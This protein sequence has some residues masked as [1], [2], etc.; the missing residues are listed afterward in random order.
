LKA[1]KDL[2][3]TRDELNQQISVFARDA[4][5]ARQRG[6]L[7][8]AHEL[9]EKAYSL[10]IEMMEAFPAEVTSSDYQ[11]AAFLA[12]NAELYAIA[13]ELALKGLSGV[14][15]EYIRY[16][17]YQLLEKIAIKTD[18]TLGKLPRHDVGMPT[19]NPE[20][21]HTALNYIFERLTK[22]IAT[23]GT[24]GFDFILKSQHYTPIQF[25]ILNESY[26]GQIMVWDNSR[27][28]DIWLW[29]IDSEDLVQE[30]KA[31]DDI[32]DLLIVMGRVFEAF[33]EQR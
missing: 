24:Q 13:K 30:N 23:Q 21:R 26:M 8:I 18:D 32:A 29:K 33:E 3:P 22:M 1:G 5:A 19:V 4:H 12:Y 31:Y 2:M 17:L 11:Y 27:T 9:S 20:Y 28:A 6:E 14:A 16:E 15:H 10:K 25:E 7:Q